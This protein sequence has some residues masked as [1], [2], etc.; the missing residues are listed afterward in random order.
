MENIFQPVTRAGIGRVAE[1]VVRCRAGSRI[2]AAGAILEATIAAVHDSHASCAF[3]RSSYARLL[4][5]GWQAAG[6]RVA[7]RM[8]TPEPYALTA[9]QP[10]GADDQPARRGR[11]VQAEYQT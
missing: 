10:H 6:A 2:T 1:P 4:G 5:E 9:G 7:M 11:N 3:P 8:E